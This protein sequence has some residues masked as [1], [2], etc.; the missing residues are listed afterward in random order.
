[1]PLS[2]DLI[3]SF[4]S[5]LEKIVNSAVQSAGK[6]TNLSIKSKISQY[7]DSFVRDSKIQVEQLSP[8]LAINNSINNNDPLL[9]LTQS[10]TA[11]LIADKMMGQES[12]ELIFSDDKHEAYSTAIVQSLKSAIETFEEI[13]SAGL[14]VTDSDLVMADPANEDTLKLDVDND[15]YLFEV[16]LTITGHGEQILYLDL[17]SRNINTLLSLF[18]GSAQASASGTAKET[19]GDFMGTDFAEIMDSHDP[20]D[21]DTAKNLNLLMDIRLGLIVELG[22]AEM[23]LRDI[24]K[25]TKGSIIELD[26]LSG[27]PVDLFVNNKLIARG[28]VVVIDDNFGLRINQL[29]GSTSKDKKLIGAKD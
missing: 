28:E 25:L 3:K 9:I 27:E 4:V 15:R 19:V 11:A 6:L 2:D 12:E 10:E 21:V 8:V 18:A 13:T 14:Q 5:T 17:S 29:A 1:M 24:L 22:R 26:R 20:N 16:S 23:H 7:G